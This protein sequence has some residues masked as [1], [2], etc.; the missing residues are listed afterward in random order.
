M[1]HSQAH[2]YHW[3]RPMHKCQLPASGP[4]L[5]FGSK[6]LRL[7]AALRVSASL[8]RDPDSAVCP[9][10]REHLR[11][12]RDALKRSRPRHPSDD[13]PRTCYGFLAGASPLEP[14]RAPIFR[15]HPMRVQAD[16][17]LC[18]RCRARGRGLCCHQHSRRR[19]LGCV[20]GGPPLISSHA[21]NTR[22]LIE[23]NRPAS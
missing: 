22:A 11:I 9:T 23:L 15:C 4:E 3:P 20:L 5:Y 2:A 14:P 6:L 10:S 17:A 1:Q 18:E 19:W 8:R 16:G 7:S 13:V 12:R 21:P